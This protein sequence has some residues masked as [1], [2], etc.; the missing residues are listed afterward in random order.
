M[1]EQLGTQMKIG[2]L[3]EIFIGDTAMGAPVEEMTEEAPKLVVQNGCWV[4]PRSR[5]VVVTQPLDLNGFGEGALVEPSQA[6]Q[7]T[8]R[9]S[10]GKVLVSGVGTIGQ[11]AITHLSDHKQWIEEGTV[12]GIIEPVTE[13]KEG[14]TLVAV[15]TAGVEKK[16]RREHKFDS[17]IGEGLMPTDREKIREV[18]VEYGDYFSWPG[19]QLGLCTAAGQT[20]EARGKYIR[21]REAETRETIPLDEEVQEARNERVD[22]QV[23]RSTRVRMPPVRYG[24]MPQVAVGAL[25]LLLGLLGPRMGEL[26][27]PTQLRSVDDSVDDSEREKQAAEHHTYP[28]ELWGVGAALFMASVAV[29]SIQWCRGRKGDVNRADLRERLR[30]VEEFVEEEAKKRRA[31]RNAFGDECS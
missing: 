29:F 8:K 1:L 27:P 10:T 7:R 12:L 2:T 25:L 26:F 15:A 19:D 14:D 5:K 22:D 17:R 23:R 13:I 4:S 9:V 6:L 28:F 31:R 30:I 11:M 20:I 16:A 3:P 21:D 18:L 24:Q